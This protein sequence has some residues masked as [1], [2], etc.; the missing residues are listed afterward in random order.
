VGNAHRKMLAYLH[1]ALAKAQRNGEIQVGQF[2]I[3]QK[4]LPNW[5]AFFC[6]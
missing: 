6:K 3:Q 4:M 2:L 5:E 1:F